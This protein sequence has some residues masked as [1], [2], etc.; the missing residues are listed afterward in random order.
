MAR[1]IPVC[2]DGGLEFAGDDTDLVQ[3]S[4][5]G[6][7]PDRIGEDEIGLLVQRGP[8]A[9][10]SSGNTAAQ[11]ASSKAA[12]RVGSPAPYLRTRPHMVAR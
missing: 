5:L 6:G 3:V 1:G 12:I 9:G 11:L 10:S 4:G 2:A 8:A 7:L